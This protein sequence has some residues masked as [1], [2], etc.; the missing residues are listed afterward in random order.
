M[1]KEIDE[2]FEKFWKEN[3]EMIKKFIKI[4][5]LTGGLTTLEKI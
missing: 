2:T 5:W 3:E 4:I 1:S